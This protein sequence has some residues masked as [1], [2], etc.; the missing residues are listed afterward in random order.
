VKV[1]IQNRGPF[2]ET[3][4]NQAM[5]ASVLTLTAESLGSCANPAPV[6]AS[7]V[8]F[9]LTVASKASLTVTYN[10]TFN[11][12]NDAA[13][14]TAKD[15]NHNDYRFVAT[16]NHA[17]I[18]GSADSHTFDDTCPRTVTPPYLIDPYPDGTIKDKGC[19]K[20]KTDGTYGGDVVTDIVAP[21]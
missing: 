20:I 11:C 1:V 21:K 16:V 10:V 4:T 3:I 9:P 15:P 7:P 19:G 13:K 17:A 12:V 14:S 18:D 2:T 8:K 5:L 6:L